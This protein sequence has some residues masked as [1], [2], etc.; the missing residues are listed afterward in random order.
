MGNLYEVRPDGPVEWCFC[1]RPDKAGA[2]LTQAGVSDVFVLYA[3]NAGD[4]PSTGTRPHRVHPV[5]QIDRWRDPQRRQRPNAARD[6]KPAH[7]RKEQGQVSQTSMSTVQHRAACSQIHRQPTWT[8]RKRDLTPDLPPSTDTL[9]WEARVTLACRARPL[10]V[11]AARVPWCCVPGP[12]RPPG[13]V[14][15][16]DRLREDG[17]FTYRVGQPEGRQVLAI[18]AVDPQGKR[19]QVV[20]LGLERN[21]K[22]LEQQS[23][24][25]GEHDTPE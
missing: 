21:T 9:P 12:V 1:E 7:A 20:V 5:R 25:E 24:E 11:I 6:R 19:R 10:P 13:G 16:G 22:E 8:C 15:L 14:C 2:V 23:L 18:A 3:S 17:S 4:R